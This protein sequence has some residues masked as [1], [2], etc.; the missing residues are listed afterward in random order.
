MSAW[1]RPVTMAALAVA[2]LAPAQAAAQ[3]PAAQAE[4]IN[5]DGKKLF[6]AKN[7]EAA[8]AKFREAAALSPEG[9][10]YFNM[11]YALNFLE[12]YEEAI[13][14]CEQVEAAGADP[15]LTEKTRKALA[16]LREKAASQRVTPAAATGTDPGE[17]EQPEGQD[18]GQRD[19][20]GPPPPAPGGADPF[21]MATAPPPP[22]GS[23]KWSIGGSLGGLANLNV[24]RRGDFEG[25]EIYGEGGADLR[26]FANILLSE[27]ARFG[28]QGS[29]SFGAIAPVD[30]SG[31]DNNNLV[32][33]DFGGAL[34]FHLPLG[35]RL[36]LTPLAGPLVSVQQPEQ[37]SQGFIA[38]GARG[39][40]GL[41][42]LFGQRLEHAFSITPA[43]NVYFPASG[44]VDGE[45]PFVY[46]L[47]VTHSTFGIA[48][49]YTYRF[50]TPFGAVPLITLE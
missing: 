12:R 48:F 30:R 10:F 24:G 4:R 37:V 40:L 16:A 23:Y 28:V 6:A 13:H 3:S 25:Q 2:L 43:I 8:H 38:L 7:Y 9:R 15:E 17:P 29:L 46:G 19:P 42:L 32:L 45:D 33:T 1:L 20:G 5:D 34:F 47:D 50:S 41:S 26:L 27:A 49:G 36:L 22:P 14:A 39:E 18:P 44:D 11:C 31:L 35:S 21:I